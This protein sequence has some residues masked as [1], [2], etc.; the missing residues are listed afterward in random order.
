M[1]V[2]LTYLRSIGYSSSS[3]SER[4]LRMYK[5]E[6]LLIGAL[7]SLLVLRGFKDKA[8]NKLVGPELFNSNYS[9][10]KLSCAST[11]F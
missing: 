5:F 2:M 8:L 10:L 4:A 11:S 6:G 3:I 9:F 1:S 7:L